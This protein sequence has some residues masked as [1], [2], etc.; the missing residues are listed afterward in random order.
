MRHLKDKYI[1]GKCSRYRQVSLQYGGSAS[2][3]LLYK[4]R[5]CYEWT[6]LLLPQSDLLPLSVNWFGN[7][8]RD[9]CN[10]N[11][12]LD[13]HLA[14]ADLGYYRGGSGG[15]NSRG[16]IFAEHFTKMKTNWTEK[17]RQCPSPPNP[18]LLELFRTSI[19]LKHLDH[20]ASHSVNEQ[21]IQLPI[22]TTHIETRRLATAYPRGKVISSA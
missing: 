20:I 18:P 5:Y 2:Q 10:L 13:K 7:Q 19:T 16:I 15:A 3:V 6:R 12:T 4:C 11:F 14:V 21:F 1:T 9:R 17:G 8:N 22:A